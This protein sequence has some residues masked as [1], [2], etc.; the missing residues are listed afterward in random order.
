VVRIELSKHY[1]P[2]HEI[3]EL[4]E[5]ASVDGTIVIEVDNYQELR[6]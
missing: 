5:D 6:N 2:H 3:E 1:V 4:E